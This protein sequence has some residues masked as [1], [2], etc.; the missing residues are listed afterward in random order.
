MPTLLE[1]PWTLVIGQFV[2]LTGTAMAFA[3]LAYGEQDPITIRT[4]KL[5]FFVGMFGS[6]TFLA[7]LTLYLYCTTC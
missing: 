3:F 4:A 1:Q 2:C 6:L 7:M 5:L